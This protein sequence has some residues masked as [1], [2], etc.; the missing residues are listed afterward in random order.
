M[1]CQMSIMCFDIGDGPWTFILMLKSCGVGECIWIIM[2]ALVL[3]LSFDI[4]DGLGPELDNTT[5]S[6]PGLDQELDNCNN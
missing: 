2:S 6:R 3:F 4:G 5:L 1:Q